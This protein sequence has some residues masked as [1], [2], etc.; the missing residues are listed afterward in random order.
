MINFRNLFWLTLFA[1][2]IFGFAG[3]S[4]PNRSGNSNKAFA[5]PSH[6]TATLT[7][8]NNIVLNWKNNATAVGGNWVEFA[9]PGSEY[10]K[11]DVFMSDANNTTFVH[12]RLAPR[13]TFV[14]RILPFFGCATKPV[15]ITTGAESTNASTLEEGPIISTNEVASVENI[16]KHSI[17]SLQ[18]FAKAAPADLT[19]TLSSPTSV[20][21]HWKD[22]AAD[23]EGCFV[24]IGSSA[25]GK[26]FICAMLSS[27]TMSF[28]KTGL[29]PETKCY[30]R[31]RAY[32][33]GKPSDTASTTTLPQ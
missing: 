4:T 28:R 14:Y 16:P 32:F 18:T 2:L 23:D 12:P 26:F 21:L 15:E 7:N 6:L 13:T 22:S 5:S 30:F 8:G 10:T 33:Y 17:R 20:D 9:T 29:P 1:A 11:L 31:V 19:A 3:C 25:N 27:N 24:E